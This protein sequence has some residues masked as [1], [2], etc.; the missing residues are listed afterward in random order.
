MFWLGEKNDI[1]NIPPVVMGLKVRWTILQ[2][3]LF[4]VTL[5]NIGPNSEPMAILLTC[6]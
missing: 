4:K 3:I 5:A 2:S 1:I 6:L